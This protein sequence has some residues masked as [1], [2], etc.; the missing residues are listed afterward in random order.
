[1]LAAEKERTWDNE[2]TSQELRSLTNELLKFEPMIRL[3]HKNWEEIKTHQFFSRVNFDWNSLAGK[4]MVSPLLPILEHR[5]EYRKIDP[6]KI[7]P[8]YNLEG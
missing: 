4:S 7:R 2:G 1:M 5:M 6:M 3:G 8:G